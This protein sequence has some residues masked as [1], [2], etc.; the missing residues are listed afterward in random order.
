MCAMIALLSEG[1]FDVI[2]PAS[3]REVDARNLRPLRSELLSVCSDVSIAMRGFT[4]HSL[5]MLVVDEELGLELSNF[6]RQ[7]KLKPGIDDHH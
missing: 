3:N 2:I 7:L 4:D 6:S 1:K 5:R